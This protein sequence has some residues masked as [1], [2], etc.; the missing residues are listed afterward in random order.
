MHV[1]QES[2]PQ[3]GYTNSGRQVVKGRRAHHSNSCPGKAVEVQAGGFEQCTVELQHLHKTEPVC[4]EHT[5][6]L[7]PSLSVTGSVCCA[8]IFA[9][10]LNDRQPVHCTC[11]L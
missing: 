5:E 11:K 9:K 6:L 3:C 8:Q 10:L 7:E 1:K 2:V 4:G